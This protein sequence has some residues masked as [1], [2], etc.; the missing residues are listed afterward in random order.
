MPLQTLNERYV[1]VKTC[2][3]WY[4]ARFFAVPLQS[5]PLDTETENDMLYSGA[6]PPPSNLTDVVV[7]SGESGRAHGW[8]M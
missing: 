7:E 6:G 3:Q 5:E 1:I 2:S 8:L 4:C